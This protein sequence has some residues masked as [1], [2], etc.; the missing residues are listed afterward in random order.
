M[1][2][3]TTVNLVASFPFKP[4]I[5]MAFS[6]AGCNDIQ[7]RRGNEDERVRTSSET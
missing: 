7:A 5:L 3:K 6:S 1:Q 4:F 2:F